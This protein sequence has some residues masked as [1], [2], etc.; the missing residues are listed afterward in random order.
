VFASGVLAVDGGTGTYGYGSAPPAVV[1]KVG[2]M[3]AICASHGVSLGAV[4]LQF[5][6]GHPAVAAVIPGAVS[7]EQVRQNAT[8]FTAHIPAALWEELK[9]EGLLRAD[10]PVPR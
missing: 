9:A 6:F 8:R 10:A 2:R 3:R 7:A 4:A 5:P 1:D